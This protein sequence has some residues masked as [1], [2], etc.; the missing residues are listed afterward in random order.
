MSKRIAFLPSLHERDTIDQSPITSID[1]QTA[2]LNYRDKEKLC[3]PDRA[4]EKSK[5]FKLPPTFGKY[6]SK[7]VGQE[8]VVYD[9]VMLR[10]MRKL[11]RGEPKPTRN[12][13]SGVTTVVD[14]TTLFM[15]DT[16][17]VW[18]PT[19]VMPTLLSV[20]HP[21]LEAYDSVA[22]T[23]AID[24]ERNYS[25]KKWLYNKKS[26]DNFNPDLS[27]RDLN[28]GK[29]LRRLQRKEEKKQS[30]SRKS[31][32]MSETNEMIKIETH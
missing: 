10:Y 19:S 21:L 25:P 28:R 3:I 26:M 23:R 22:T 8:F 9:E 15:P 18:K 11:E 32:G 2:F 7:P 4:F 1:N 13:K 5:R 6:L 29:Y 12:T 31:M 30:T 24:C 20:S 27:K 14:K 17:G 16:N